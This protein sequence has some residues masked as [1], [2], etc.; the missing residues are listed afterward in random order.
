MAL[1]VTYVH[2]CLPRLRRYRIYMFWSC[3]ERNWVH[4]QT[5]LY[6]NGPWLVS[7]LQLTGQATNTGNKCRPRKNEGILMHIGYVS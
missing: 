7:V 5:G 4:E 1:V 3:R 6:A 2:L